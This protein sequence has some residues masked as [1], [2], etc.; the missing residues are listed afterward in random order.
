[1]LFDYYLQLLYKIE[2]PLL[3]NKN[4]VCDRYIYDTIITDIAVDMGY[5]EDEIFNLIERCLSILPTPDVVFLIDVPEEVAY[6]RK[7]DVP[8]IGYL[9]DRRKYYIAIAKKYNMIKING[10]EDMKDIE[11]KI[12]NETLLKWRK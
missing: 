11:R 12:F 4:V 8:A 10:N 9:R 5:S 7:D 3:L 2:V 6:N 1:M